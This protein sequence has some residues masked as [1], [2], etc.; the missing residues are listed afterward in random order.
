MSNPTPWTIE[1]S[2]TGSG[3][4]NAVTDANGGDVRLSGVST[5]NSLDAALTT[6]VVVRSIN[7]FEPL[8]LALQQC[9]HELGSIH[10]AGA[11]LEY[12]RA[13]SAGLRMALDAL[14]KLSA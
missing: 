5:T 1:F 2:S 12:A 13:H 10:G 8:V 6:E 4:I 7:A 9:A 14:E 11:D 3:R